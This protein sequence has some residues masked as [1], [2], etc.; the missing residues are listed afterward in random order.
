M[1]ICKLR[2]RSQGWTTLPLCAAC[3]LLFTR[4]VQGL[5]DKN[6]GKSWEIKVM[7][8]GPLKKSRTHFFHEPFSSLLRHVSNLSTADVQNTD[9]WTNSRCMLL[10][11]QETQHRLFILRTR[12]A[13]GQRLVLASPCRLGFVTLVFV[14]FACRGRTGL[15]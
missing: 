7:G 4:A 3:A 1:A 14:V 12:G 6:R 13:F 11:S 10:L 8:S 9:A 15:P 5:A 2:C